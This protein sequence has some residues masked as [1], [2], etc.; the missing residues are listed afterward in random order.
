MKAMSE[1]EDPARRGFLAATA[2]GLATLTFAENGVAQTAPVPPFAYEEATLASLEEAL[3]KGSVTARA[4]T[5]AYLDRIAVLDRAGPALRAVIELNPEALAIAEARDAERKEGRVRGPLHG[6]PIL[7]KDNI[8]CADK[9]STTAGSLALEGLRAAEDAPIVKRLRDA[10]AV[11]LGKTNLSEWAN[12]RS[13]NSLSGWSSR[14]GQTRNPY[15]LERTPSGSS[16][17]SAVAVAAN[18][19]AAAIG[20]ETDGSIVSPAACNNIVGFKPSMGLV[21]RSG[22]VP[23]SHSQDT[24][25]PMARSVEDCAR[26]MNVIAGADASD[27]V[28]QAGDI[29][30]KVDFTA[31]LGRADLQGVK[32]GVGR[33]YFGV[34][35]KVDVLM[36]AALAKLK[37]LGAE[38][39]DVEIPG[40][41]KF[42]SH[43]I[44]VLLYDFKADINAWLTANVK[45]GPVR[46]LADLI[47]FNE[48]NREKMMPIFGQNLLTR[49]QAKGPLTE[50]EYL[51]ALATSRDLTRAQG[52]DAVVAKY[53]VD[54]IVAATTSPPWVRDA[55]TGDSGRGG[56]AGMA[57][58]SGYPHITVPA[59]FIVPPSPQSGLAPVGLSMFGPAFSDAKLLSIAQ[60][61]ERATRHRRP[62][63]F[64][65]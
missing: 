26:L 47:E 51:K 10:G 8:A 33:Q 55:V 43:E 30:R 36:E 22:I 29:P 9:T 38:L 19:C 52:I 11:I 20:T 56:C 7:L 32:L 28:T 49:A 4:L 58:V 42:S 40:F 18:L 17:G 24:A 25:G 14:G 13:T 35:E 5:S 57:A 21:P 53:G 54:A 62:P 15:A 3:R 16:S 2:G 46:S 48:R 6:V 12:F 64:A 59:G 61:F 27:A 41:G 31:L 34:N 65:R 44:E 23:L 1:I 60:V 63:P 39:V 37:E 50:P 45:D